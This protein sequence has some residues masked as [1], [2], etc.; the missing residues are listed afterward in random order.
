MLRGKH[1]NILLL[2]NFF[3]FFKFFMLLTGCPMVGGWNLEQL[4]CR[5]KGSCEQCC[6]FDVIIN[7]FHKLTYHENVWFKCIWNSYLLFCNLMYLKYDYIFPIHWVLLIELHLLCLIRYMRS[8][9]VARGSTVQLPLPESVEQAW[10]LKWTHCAPNL[11]VR[12]HWTRPL[13]LKK[14]GI[15]FGKISPNGFRLRKSTTQ[16]CCVCPVFIHDRSC[17]F[18]CALVALAIIDGEHF[19]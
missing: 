2:I 11:S 6:I 4:Y 14:K 10:I 18:F 13:H 3:F 9:H 19:V 16:E 15:S 12:V 1:V 17:H 8:Q 7:W 5:T